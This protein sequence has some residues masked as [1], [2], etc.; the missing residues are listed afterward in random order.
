VWGAQKCSSA[1]PPGLLKPAS[2]RLPPQGRAGRAWK[3][4]SRWCVFSCRSCPC[5]PV[6]GNFN[7]SPSLDPEIPVKELSLHQVASRVWCVDTFEEYASGVPRG[8]PPFAIATSAFSGGDYRRQPIGSLLSSQLSEGISRSVPER[9]PVTT[10]SRRRRIVVG[11]CPS[12][13]RS[14]PR[15]RDELQFAAKSAKAT[16]SHRKP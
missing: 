15:R 13:C 3:R 14:S 10:T 4:C 1:R 9:R 16:V 12:R 5:V 8:S 11:A 7:G 6:L 2:Q